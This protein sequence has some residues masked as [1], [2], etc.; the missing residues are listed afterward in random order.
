MGLR[1][2][3]ATLAL[4]GGRPAPTAHGPAISVQGLD[5][6]FGERQVLTDVT[7]QIQPGE[8]VVVVGENGAGKSSLTAALAGALR[9]VRGSVDIFGVPPA[10]A[11]RSGHLA[12]VWQTPALVAELTVLDN[13]FLGREISRPFLSKRRM[14]QE[15]VQVLDDLGI[16]IPLGVRVADLSGGQQ[17][18]IALAGAVM[19]RP[20]VLLLDEPTTAL[21]LPGQTRVDEQLRQLRDRGVTIVL[22]S[23]R[24]EQVTALADRVLALRHGRLVTD[25]TTVELTT[26]DI[27]ALMSGL[28]GGLSARRHLTQLSG[29]V[30]QL[31]DVEPSASLPLIVSSIANTLG[32]P[33][34]CVHLADDA[35]PG[36]LNLAASV[37]LSP[38][39]L[40]HFGSMQTGDGS[41]VAD[42][43]AS[44]QTTVLAGTDQPARQPSVRP[45][46]M[47]SVPI[48]G[49]QGRYGVISGLADVPGRPPPDQLEVISVYAS[50]AATAIERER[51]LDRV[52]RSNRV[53]ESVRKV[54]EPL[55]TEPDEP[56]ALQGAMAVLRRELDAH[57]LVLLRLTQDGP[58]LRVLAET[59]AGPAGPGGARDLCDALIGPSPHYGGALGRQVGVVDRG[60]GEVWQVVTDIDTDR[61]VLAA[62]LDDDQPD[63]LELLRAAAYSLTLS[64]EREKAQDAMARARA[65]TQASEMQRELVRKLSHELRTPLTAI[66]G[67][68]S[69]LRQQDVTWEPD[70]QQRFI[71]V[72]ASEADRLQRL[73]K[74]LLDSASIAA[75]RM[76][77][78]PDWCDTQVVIEAAVS[79]LGRPDASVALH[80]AEVPPI[81]AD[82][83]RI[84]QVLINLLDN[85]FR[86]GR[87]RVGLS[88]RPA[89]MDGQAAVAIDVTD[90]GCGPRTELGVDV[91]E[92]YVHGAT[93][94][95]GLGLG[96][97][98]SRAI[99]HA[100]HG[101]LEFVPVPAGTCVRLTLPVDPQPARH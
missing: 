53:L 16:D 100:H 76:P 52:T 39:R 99:A 91:F 6:S 78:N 3:V 50:L 49:H 88:S 27:V 92:P 46:S 12:A 79:A 37:G 69:T 56:S 9:P 55:A 75:G 41:T 97:S 35:D 29:L 82:H 51:L 74:E 68:A 11:F 8:L 67:Y 93:D 80:L 59:A 101:T 95:P 19:R 45:V 33:Q 25:A 4:M 34:V 32:Q 5:A 15:A 18:L 58:V 1:R 23:H 54:L 17:Q 10:S 42:A 14:R 66:V 13:L 90:E 72:M 20:R 94:V 21:S 64:A 7:F 43:F 86:H 77:I 98:I 26:D 83:D 84:E 28:P 81:W 38:Q 85:A 71:G 44:G 24:V 31:S 96:L 57:E 60:P 65:A 48:Q 62:R 2:A 47:W 22:V 30:D 36:R 61:Q 70:T 63:R 89:L 40:R 73:V 87:G